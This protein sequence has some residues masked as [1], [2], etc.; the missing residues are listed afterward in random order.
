VCGPADII[1]GYEI[2]D[3]EAGSRDQPDSWKTTRLPP[4]VWKREMS[5]YHF[6]PLYNIKI[7]PRAHAHAALDRLCPDDR[8]LALG[9]TGTLV[10]GRN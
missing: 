10:C 3:R 9:I 2:L 6:Q 8:T 7:G 5:A 4:L 1:L